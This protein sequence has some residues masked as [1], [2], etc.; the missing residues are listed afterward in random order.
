MTFR[1]HWSGWRAAFMP[2]PGRYCW[3]RCWTLAAAII[4]FA[5]ARASEWRLSGN[6]ER[7]E[8]GWCTFTPTGVVA[9][10]RAGC[11]HRR[12]CC[13]RGQPRFCRVNGATHGTILA[14][15]RT[16]SATVGKCVDRCIAGAG[17]RYRGASGVCPTAISAGIVMPSVGGPF[18]LLLLWRRRDRL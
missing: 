8:R 10:S 13:L 9:F 6:A 16:N 11:T 15:W 7:R 3:W 5:T 17:H 2:P 1:L 12:Q 4:L 14:A 18:F